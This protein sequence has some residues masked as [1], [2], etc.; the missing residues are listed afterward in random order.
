MI[1]L[2]D[3]LTSGTSYCTSVVR[4]TFYVSMWRGER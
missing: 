3:I 1:F 2:L 4:N